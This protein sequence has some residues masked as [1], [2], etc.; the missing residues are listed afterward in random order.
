MLLET[1]YNSTFL[2]SFN[3]VVYGKKNKWAGAKIA[4]E[5]N[6]QRVI[7]TD[8]LTPLRFQR[9]GILQTKHAQ[10]YDFCLLITKVFVRRTLVE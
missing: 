1:P 10:R 4:I 8:S 6:E 9:C 2:R 7:A 3:R 5:D